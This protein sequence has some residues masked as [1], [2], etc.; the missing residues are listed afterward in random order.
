M[1][2]LKN[3]TKVYKT[4][5]L[6]QKALDN[7]SLSFR[8]NEFVAILGVSGSGKTTMLNIIGGLD[9]YTSGDLIIDG[10][11]TKDYKDRDWDTYRNHRIGF[12]FQ[13]YN[14][15]IHQ[16]VLSNVEL[17][18]T[19]S[20]VSR[21][22][23]KKR[24]LEALESV[25][26]KEHTHKRPNQLSGGQMQRVAIARALVNN[27]DILLADEPT[28]ALDSET[29]V[30]VMNLLKEV[31]KDR[32][33][34]MVTHNP[35]WAE[36]YASR[37]ITLKDGQI[38]SDSEPYESDRKI[39]R[40]ISKLKHTSMSL[41]TSLSLSFNNL[42]TKKF[43]TLLTAF[44]GSIGIIGIALIISLSS[45][46]NQYILDIQKDTMAS[47]PIMIEAQSIDVSSFIEIG[48]V[49]GANREIDHELDGVYTNNSNIERFS[50]VT[51]SI[52]E[53]NLTKFKEQLDDE[54][55]EIH[56]Y[57]GENGVVY[58]YDVQYKT[59]T[60]DT[61]DVLIDTDAIEIKEEEQ[62]STG[63]GV[64]ISFDT[65]LFQ[66]LVSGQSEDEPISQMIL[67]NYHLVDG[68]W[69]SQFNELILVMDKNYEVDVSELYHLG[70]LPSEEYFDLEEKLDNNED[71]NL[72]TKKIDNSSIIGKTYY[73]LPAVDQYELDEENHAVKIP[74]NPEDIEK[75]L[76]K[77]IETEIVGIIA[78]NED[79]DDE[80]FL[81]TVG[82]LEDL[83][84]EIMT[85]T[86]IHEIVLQQQND[87][88][89]SV[90]SGL[91]FAPGSDEERIDDAIQYISSL[92]TSDKAA[93]FMMIASTMQGQDMTMIQEMDEVML[94]ATF[95]Q[96]LLEPED[97]VMLG[98]Y[99][100]FISPGT[101]EEALKTLGVV[102][103]DTPT[104]ISLYTDS[105]EDKD[106]VAEWITR[107]NEMAS[108][109]DQI[110]YTDFVG[111]LMSSIS[112]IINVISSVLIAFVA[113]S[114][115]VSS[116]MIGIITYISVLER[117]KEIGILRALGASKRNIS[118]VFN[119]ETFIIGLT[120]GALG[121][122]IA[123]LI[124][125][126]GNAIIHAITGD[127]GVNAFI[128]IDA[129]IILIV[130]SCV[131]TLIGG[132][133]PARKAAKKD[134]VEALRTE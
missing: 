15:I 24:A 55:N 96:Y 94:A 118:S 100:R 36:K 111:L 58:S 133:I 57:L 110:V 23:R 98:I 19:I 80:L 50:Q 123:H 77:A 112:T 40:S 28:G 131:L 25:G 62:Q 20:G 64:N 27:P 103:F 129:T 1:L 91:R 45:G 33:V 113:V 47:Y 97:D 93:L 104:S 38:T 120:S 109:K 51:S 11:S 84:N 70:L 2:Q 86:H 116:I 5:E 119:A 65:S 132:F 74:A 72:V 30:Q 81:G 99:D 125:I 73:F 39:E 68:K 29:S 31:A 35:E 8:K 61:E 126:P 32:L 6:T 124:L 76:D 18:L 46:A 26:L 92:N 87:Q 130:L 43:R 41:L 128:P 114:L 14:L 89:H 44:A 10:T 66:P 12:V 4:G 83:N 107:Y 56:D 121:I 37:T 42:W 115:I 71:L 106:K 3:I 82:Y 54:S 13:S 108:E 69:P 63:F 90:F 78:L 79:R 17:A 22:E 53:N 34:I 75:V 95:D 49:D 7:V 88:E 102:S 85:Y 117:I 52:S 59:Y 9:R 60:Y 67:D 21:S 105:F 122:L 134:P 48:D 101:Y 16:S 127:I